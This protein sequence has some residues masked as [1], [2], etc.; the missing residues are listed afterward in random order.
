MVNCPYLKRKLGFF[1]EGGE[2][3]GKCEGRKGKR[4]KNKKKNRIPK[5]S[6]S[7][8][9]GNNNTIKLKGLEYRI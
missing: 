6:I 4:K 3:M 2:K 8:K 9:Y 5:K 7:E 1:G